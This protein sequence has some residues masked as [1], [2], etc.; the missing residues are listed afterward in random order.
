[1]IPNIKQIAVK[2]E[3]EIK[4]LRINFVKWGFLSIGFNLNDGQECLAG[5]E[6]S[7]SHTFD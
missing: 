4:N 7:N 3:E 2:S 5:T 6:F 1:M